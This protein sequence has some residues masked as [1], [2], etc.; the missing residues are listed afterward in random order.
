MFQTKFKA[1]RCHIP[2]RPRVAQGVFSMITHEILGKPA[3]EMNL[4]PTPEI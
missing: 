1:V 3:Q 2:G 4:M